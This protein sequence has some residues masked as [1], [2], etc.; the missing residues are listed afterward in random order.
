MSSGYTIVNRTIEGRGLSAW[1]R[2]NTPHVQIALFGIVLLVVPLLLTDLSLYVQI[3]LSAIVATGLA[4]FMGYAGQAALGQSAFVGIGA[5]TV[6]VFS[7][8]W[9]LPS[10]LGLIAAP[11]IAGLFAALVGWPLLRLRGHYLAFG[12]LA[13]LVLVQTAMSAVDFFGGGLGLGGIA[14][15]FGGD[16]QVLHLVLALIAGAV[17]VLGLLVAHR[18]VSSRFGRGIRALSGSES[19][20]ASAGVPVLGSKLKVFVIAA[21]FAGVAGAL[22]ALWTPFVSQDSFPTSGSF[23]YVIMV[24]VGGA[25]SIWGGIVGTLVVELVL[26]ALNV[27][28]SQPGFPADAATILQYSGYGVVLVAF[29]LLLP[30]GIVPSVSAALQRRRLGR[31][32]TRAE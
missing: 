4:L 1:W 20:A 14:P 31:A 19:A 22:T 2:R 11:V 12:T 25:T 30:D 23:A 7:V 28:A 17:L 8:R 3:V 18:V 16:I 32:S 24:V 29:L 27:L 9:G 5:L 6:A 10:W 13:F 15:L 26:N 21:A